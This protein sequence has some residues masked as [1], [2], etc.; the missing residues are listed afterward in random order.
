MAGASL[1]KM[2]LLLA[3]GRQELLRV[4]RSRSIKTATLLLQRP[5]VL[6]E[7]PTS[8]QFGVPVSHTLRAFKLIIPENNVSLRLLSTRTTDK[9]RRKAN[10]KD[11][12]CGFPL[13]HHFTS[14]PIL[15]EGFACVR[16]ER[17]MYWQVLCM[18]SILI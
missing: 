18:G 14:S 12:V 2:C 13:F 3:P 7:P 4:A 10:V 5:T 17:G 9:T 16:G 15:S 1:H 11:S 8:N 6:A